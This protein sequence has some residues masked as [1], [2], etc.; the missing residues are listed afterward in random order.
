METPC[1]HSTLERLDE[2]PNFSDIASGVYRCAACGALLM[3]PA[4]SVPGIRMLLEK[5]AQR[6]HQ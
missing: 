5:A 4:Q 3:F 1:R 2:R 6:D